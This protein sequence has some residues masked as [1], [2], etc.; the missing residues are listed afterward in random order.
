MRK[1]KSIN[2]LIIIA[3]TGFPYGEASENFV[4]TMAKGLE[5]NDG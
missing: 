3:S 2:S 1:N 4:R 5:K